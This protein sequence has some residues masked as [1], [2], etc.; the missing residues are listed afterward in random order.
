MFADAGLTD[1]TLPT[2]LTHIGDGALFGNTGLKS[3]VLPASLTVIGAH[4]FNSTKLTELELPKSLEQIGDYAL[5]GQ[6]GI[7][8]LVLPAS[9]VY[10]GSYAMEN[11][12]GLVEIDA[13][14]LPQIPELGDNVWEGVAQKEVTLLLTSNGPDFENAPQ[15]MEFNIVRDREA[16]LSEDNFV[17]AIRITAKFVGNTLHVESSGVQ[18]AKVSIFDIN[19]RM[20]LVGD[21]DGESIDIDTSHIAGAV[22]VVGVTTADGDSKAFKLAR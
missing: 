12:T 1:L 14:N 17:D 10:I 6:T 11:M 19:G 21:V 9:L 2:T 5:L 18:L 20:L 22:F 7:E 15:W 3:V 16:T 4:A 8:N 13:M